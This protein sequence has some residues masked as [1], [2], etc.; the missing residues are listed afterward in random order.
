[1]GEN[2]HGPRLLY[3]EAS[4]NTPSRSYPSICYITFSQS[5]IAR[6]FFV[7]FACFTRS[8]H[9]H[10]SNAAIYT[11]YFANLTIRSRFRGCV[12]YKH[13]I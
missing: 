11:I 1:M 5:P 7:Q 3:I 13:T 8:F 4:D 2:E 10:I 6:L 12:T 9:L